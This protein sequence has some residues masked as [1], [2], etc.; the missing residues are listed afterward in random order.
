VISDVVGRKDALAIRFNGIQWRT[1]TSTIRQ[2]LDHLDGIVNPADATT[3]AT[4]K[5]KAKGVQETL[6]WKLERTA[7]LAD[8]TERVYFN[9]SMSTASLSQ[10]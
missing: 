7:A 5:Q 3:F 6:G 10:G 4:A 8:P 2:W 9:Y 1:G